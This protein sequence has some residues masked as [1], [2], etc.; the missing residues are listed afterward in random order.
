MEKKTIYTIGII[1]GLLAII[2]IIVA[3][4]TGFS[5]L[6]VIGSSTLSLSKVELKSSFAPLNGEAWLLTFTAGRLGQSYYGSFNSNDV[7]DGNA[8]AT[9]DFTINVQYEDQT[10]NYDIVSST[11]KTPIYDDIKEVKWTCISPTSI[12]ESQALTKWKDKYGSGYLI[13]YGGSRI[14][15]GINNC[16]AV[17][18]PTYSSV[19][20][21]SSPDLDSEYTITIDVNGKVASKTINSLSGSSQGK[22]GDYAYAVWNGNLVSGASCPDKDPYLPI[23]SNGRWIIGDSD[24]YDDYKSWLTAISNPEPSTRANAIT[25]ARSFVART[26][27]QQSF[28]ALNSATSLDYGSVKVTL[29][30]A[31][32][33]PVTSLYIKS[34]TLGIY[35]PSSKVDLYSPNS[36]CFN[37]GT[38]GSIEVGIKNT[39]DQTWTGNVYAECSSPFSSS[40]SIS[41]SLSQGESAIR[42]IPITADSSSRKTSS[43]IIRAE[44]VGSE[45]SVNVGVCVD[46]L[47]TCVANE[48]FCSTSGELAVIKMCSSDGATSSIIKTCTTGQTCDGNEC[49]DADEVKLSIFTKIKNWFSNIIN[50]IFDF[51]TILK[52]LIV[53]S[54]GIVS[55]FISSDILKS[56][57]SLEENETIRWIISVGIGIGI[58]FLLYTFIY[59]I[60][61]WIIVVLGFIYMLF[62]RKI[63]SAL[64]I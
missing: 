21:F 29:Q 19:G 36:E 25:T 63:K 1:I 37:T 59:G 61:F 42:Y 43:C 35:T 10:C 41:L 64:G 11:T 14:T 8:K 27:A 47:V 48:K 23:Y 50:G 2:S 3:L 62:G 45:D 7:I 56:I 6:S 4:T 17:G 28:G 22:I 57:K 9:E 20:A 30:D 60:V 33:F 13:V 12:T 54:L 18:S 24:Y 39:G 52:Y 16:F 34:S 51:F 55:I 53:I 44:G 49:V 31:I 46:P 32:Q 5:F 38:Q 58:G 26:K 15:E 40:R